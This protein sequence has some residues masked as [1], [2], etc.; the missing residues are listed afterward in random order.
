[1]TVPKEIAEYREK[2]GIVVHA[3]KKKDGKSSDSK[4][5]E[6]KADSSENSASSEKSSTSNGEESKPDMDPAKPDADKNSSVLST[7]NPTP[8]K[9]APNGTNG[10]EKENSAKDG[11]DQ[12]S[13][14]SKAK[15]IKR[16]SEG[17]IKA[18]VTKSSSKDSSGLTAKDS[19]GRTVKV[20]D[21][22]D[23]E[24]D[25]EFLNNRQAFLNLC[26]GNHYQF[27]Q[28]RRAKHSSMMV[29]WHL[30][31]RDAP[32]FVQQCAVCSREILT[33]YRYHCTVCAGYDQCHECVSNPSTPRH[34]HQLKPIAVEA[35]KRTELTEEQRK[36][37][38][39]SIHLHMTLL[40]HAATCSAPKCP[41][42]NC[43]KMKGLLKHGASC[44]VKAT[45]GCHIC[46]RIWALLQIHARQCK[47]N[48]C[49][50]PNCTAIRER[51]RQLKMQ[52]QAMDDRRRQEMN[53]VY[54]GS[55]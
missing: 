49:P 33:G 1:M 52:Q 54:R 39:R 18:D 5:D 26:Q 2:H 6:G 23:E 16:D 42:A 47:Q 35:G 30:H 12:S 32:A 37:R 53:R 11:N 38:Q 17:K 48:Q 14:I 55:R 28:L 24:M 10:K 8:G 9:T 4:E 40:L 27:D 15:G 45:G 36:E 41:S 46:K 43:A 20:L 50:V 29:L 7:A 22:D 44:Q 51:F 34:P 21:D 31:N 25:C 13:A 3:G 19:R